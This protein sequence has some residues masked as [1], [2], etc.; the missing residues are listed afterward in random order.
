MTTVKNG[1]QNGN[2]NTSYEKHCWVSWAS[3]VLYAT[4]HIIGH[5]SNGTFEG[6]TGVT[7]AQQ[8]CTR[9]VHRCTWSQ[10]C[11]LIG[12]LCLKVSGSK[13]WHRIELHCIQ[14]KFLV[15]HKFLEHLPS[16]LRM[17][18]GT[19]LLLLLISNGVSEFSV[20]V[21]TFQFVVYVLVLVF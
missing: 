19:I 17:F 15:P 2:K 6:I 16:P 18:S 11:S 7:H 8:T 20:L 21:L 5:F 3:R 1:M 9:N 14:C 13:N 4:W 12:R 10:L